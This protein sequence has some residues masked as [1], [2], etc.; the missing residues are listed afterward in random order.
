MSVHQLS[1]VLKANRM[2][3]TSQRI[4]IFQALLEH[5]PMT[6]SQFGD[7]LV[8]HVDLATVYRTLEL[9]EKLGI[10]RRIPINDDRMIE[11]SEL[12][13]PHHHH[14]VCKDCRS[15]LKVES[16]DLEESIFK[17]AESINFALDDHFLELR[18]MCVN[19]RMVNKI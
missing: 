12:F 6:T 4:Q 19:C 2:R 5:S 9:Y 14:A 10:A 17:F 3:V 7:H 8:G 18:G 13:A 15:H 16:N 1:T 11:P